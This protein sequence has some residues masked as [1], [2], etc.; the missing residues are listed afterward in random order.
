VLDVYASA[1]AGPRPV[2]VM[3]HGAPDVNT[4]ANLS[5]HAWRLADLGFVAFVPSWGHSPNGAYGAPDHDQLQANLTEAA[6]AV[7]FARAHAAEYGGDPTRMI[8]FGHSGGAGIA[9]M[10]AFARPDPTA[11]CLGG[12]TLGAIDVLVTWEGDWNAIDPTWD[13]ALAVDPKLVDDYTPWR[14]L[15]T[16]KDLKV[17]MLVSQGSNDPGTPYQ[18]PLGDP[19]AIASFFVARDPSGV[20]RR[21]LGANGAFAD[22]SYS[23]GEEQQLLFSVLKAQ[24]NSVSLDVMPDSTHDGIAGNGWDVFLAAFG[25]A[26][27]HD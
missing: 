26:L 22:G 27:V 7:A 23:L 10:V 18:R 16:H 12:T 19:P 11:G 2:V 1:K 20:L 4:K 13:A 15:G 24:G 17:V 21:Q 25:K 8:V 6:C 3:F 9:A 14:Y 5:Q